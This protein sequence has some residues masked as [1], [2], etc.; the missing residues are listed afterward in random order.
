MKKLLA[1]C[2]AALLL[3]GACTAMS[4][5]VKAPLFA[6]SHVGVNGPDAE[7]QAQLRD[8]FENVLKFG[9]TREIAPSYYVADDNIELYKTAGAGTHGHIGL[10]TDDLPAARAYLE[11]KGYSF[12]ESTAKF[13][14]DGVTMRL[15]YMKEEIN[16]WA[17][18]LTTSLPTLIEK[19]QQTFFFD[20]L[21]IN[22]TEE[23]PDNANLIDFFENVLQM[24]DTTDIGVSN[25]VAN[26]YLEL[27]K[28]TAPGTH[29]HFGIYVE[30]MHA[31]LDYLERAGYKVNYS[32]AKFANDGHMRLV[33]LTDEINGFAFHLTTS[34][35]R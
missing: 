32:T 17:F 28:G 4:E 21:G 34:K 16:G 18:H 33:Y 11:S 8:F 20:H 6:F 7:A 31:A 15:I 25:Y 12:D 27:Y 9:D 22:G 2:I 19:D 5:E 23:D 3:A 26:F 14:D 30:D 10:Y 1:F 35:R 13:K 24:H 29:G